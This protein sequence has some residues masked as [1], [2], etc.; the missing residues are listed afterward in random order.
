MRPKL[1]KDFPLTIIYT[2][3][4]NTKQ[5][6]SDNSVGLT[7][8]NVLE[9]YG[10]FGCKSESKILNCQNSMVMSFT[11][12][13]WNH[14]IDLYRDHFSEGGNISLNGYTWTN[15]S[16]DK[17]SEKVIR[18]LPRTV[19]EVDWNFD[20]EVDQDLI[21]ISWKIRGVDIGCHFHGQVKSDDELKK[22]IQAFLDDAAYQTS[23]FSVKRLYTLASK[24]PKKID[25]GNKNHVLRLEIQIDEISMTPINNADLETL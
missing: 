15:Q 25:M 3:Q 22:V 16:V 13:D 18:C 2:M 21:P 19:A 14:C 1:K 7:S 8:S 20:P 9:R 6:S 23:P 4:R 10:K 17:I 11:T 24:K 12:T 5:A